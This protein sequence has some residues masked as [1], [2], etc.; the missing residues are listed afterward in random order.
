[1]TRPP[2]IIILDEPIVNKIAAG[3]VVER[4]ASVVKEL[5]ENSIDAGAGKIT[6]EVAEAG[7]KLIRVSDDGCGMS[8][9]EV[10][11]SLER[12]STSKIKEEK[13]LYSIM[14]LGFRGEALPSIASVSKLEISS[15]AEDEAGVILKEE[16]GKIKEINEA[17]I[18]LGTTVIVRDLFFNTPA[19][20]KFLKS[21]GTELGHIGNIISQFIFSH[22]GISFKLIADGNELLSSPGSSSLFDSIASV[23]GSDLAKDLIPVSFSENSISVGGFVTLPTV[24]RIDRGYESFFVNKRYVRNALLSRSLEEVFRDLIPRGRYPVAI[25]FIELPAG[26]VDVNVHP[27]KREVKFVNTQK[28]LNSISSAVKNSLSGPEQRVQG[29]ESLR[30]ETGDSRLQT[31]VFFKEVMEPLQGE[32]QNLKWAPLA[33]LLNTYIIATDGRAL[34]LIDQHAAHERIIYDSL[35]DKKTFGSQ[36]LLIPESI[37][38]PPLLAQVLMD[39][40]DIFK[41]YGFDMEHFGKDTFMIRALPAPIARVSPKEVLIDMLTEIGELGKTAELEKLEEKIRAL[42]AC[43]GAVRAG[44]KLGPAEMQNLLKDLS[45]T[46]NPAT[47]PHGRPTMIELSKDELEKMFK[48][49]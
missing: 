40:M 9:D 32:L 1:M 44:D 28:V 33:Q 15:K 20:L 21:R 22:P 24:S 37:E 36:S 31:D 42:V 7:R 6:V 27:T 38:L 26:E 12:H 11:L 35:K 19:R 8:G 49:K 43:H 13:D 10:K 45:Q 30:L 25:I 47:C 2:R 23:Y 5:V 14:T 17:G 48:R 18:P 46:E 4:P 16:G 29:Q 3:E 41:D 39:K 34:V